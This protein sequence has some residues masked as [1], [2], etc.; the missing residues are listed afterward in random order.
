MSDMAEDVAKMLGWRRKDLE[1]LSTDA[2]GL[3]FHKVWRPYSHQA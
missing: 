2:G 1:A 3:T